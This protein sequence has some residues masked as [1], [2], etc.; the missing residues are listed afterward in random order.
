RRL[1]CRSWMPPRAQRARN[2]RAMADPAVLA[3]APRPVYRRIVQEKEGP[4]PSTDP[5]HAARVHGAFDSLQE[6]LAGRLDAG[7]REALAAG[8][9]AA[10]RGDAGGRGGERDGAQ[11][12]QGWLSRE[13]AEHPQVATLLDELALGGL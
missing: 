9:G 13:R 1:R 6:R 10:G 7:S 2:L 3:R 8:G 12:R 11:Q 4:G 5:E